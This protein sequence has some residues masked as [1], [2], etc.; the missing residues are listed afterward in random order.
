MIIQS[1][2]I[3]M[4]AS[5]SYKSRGGNI[6]ASIMGNDKTGFYK[7][8]SGVTNQPEQ[9]RGSFKSGTGFLM[10]GFHSV[11]E[12]KQVDMSD[13]RQSLHQLKVKTIDYLLYILFGRNSPINEEW[14]GDEEIAEN[15]ISGQENN[16]GYNFT[17]NYY[18]ETET[19]TFNTAGTVKTSDGRNIDFNVELTMS[20]S[21]MEASADI[22]S[23][24]H[25]VFMDPLVINLDC[26]SADV[27]DQKFYFDLDGDGNEEYISKLSPGSG[28]LA[29]DKNNDGVINDGTE[30]FGTQS[31]NGFA[32]LMKYDS[33][34]NGWI[35]EADEIFEQLRIWSMDEDGKSTLIGLGK[36]G[37]GAIY[38][39]SRETEFS[40][41]SDDNNTNAVVRR[42]GMF[43]YEQGGVGTMQQLDLTT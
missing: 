24:N 21:F 33:D 34:G 27:S 26:A 6:A 1:D 39:G 7:S 36:A 40:L 42:T 18:E 16:S 32:D 30:L 35:D 10:Q 17:L 31:G 22:I 9:R 4:G 8:F 20:R 41:N 15:N 38:L 13:N 11:R 25:P 2:T 3:S 23:F 29:L 12:I 28:Y 19:T 14:N 5:R 43:L 37:V